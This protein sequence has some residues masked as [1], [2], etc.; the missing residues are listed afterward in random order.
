MNVATGVNYT[1]SPTNGDNVYCT[2]ASSASC[3]TVNT[4][5]SNHINMNVENPLAIAV[6]ITQSTGLIGVGQTDVFTAI[7]TSLAPVPTYQWFLNGTAVAGATNATYTLTGAAPGT[8]V[9]HCVAG[10][11]DACYTT[12]SSNSLTVTTAALGV[13]EYSASLSELKVV[14]NPNKGTFTL[15]LT[16]IENEQVHIVITNVVGETVK[17]LNAATNNDVQISMDQPSGIYLL[18]AVTEHGT[19]VQKVVIN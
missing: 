8:A 6:S 14:P 12:A 19:F 4:V 3:R 5:T 2:M 11:G 17:V 10:S 9:V 13:H 1:Y 16:S 15:N 7:V 18:T